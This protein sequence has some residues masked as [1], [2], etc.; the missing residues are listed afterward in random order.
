[1]LTSSLNH[2]QNPYQDVTTMMV[3]GGTSKTIC[4]MEAVKSLGRR[5]GVNAKW[6]DGRTAGC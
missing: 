2:V 1:M 4:Y 6:R 5:I 3:K